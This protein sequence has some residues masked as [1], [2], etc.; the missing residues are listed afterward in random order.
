MADGKK[1]GL[2]V[3][4]GCGIVAASAVLSWF[5]IAPRA[6]EQKINASLEEISARLGRQITVSDLRLTGFRSA[7]LGQI[8]VSDAGHP[9]RI[10]IRLDGV[11]IA[12]THIPFG[13]DFSIASIEI[14]SLEVVLRRSGGT[15]NFDDILDK[16]KKRGGPEDAAAEGIS[17]WKRFVTPLPEIGIA[18]ASLTMDPVALRPDLQLGAVA[19]EALRFSPAEDHK[20][21]ET[22]DFGAPTVNGG[23]DVTGKVSFLLV[24]NKVP[25][26]YS[27]RFSGQIRSARDGFVSFLLPLSEKGAKPAFMT[28]NG[29]EYGFEAVRFA[30]PST[31]EIKMPQ[32]KIGGDP[33]FFSA[34]KF[35]AQFMQLPPKK[36]SGVYFKEIEI[37]QPQIQSAISDGVPA[38][39]QFMKIAEAG[40]RL[41]SGGGNVAGTDAAPET[42]K[43]E[44]SA[45]DYFFSQRLFVS[46]G[47]FAL[48][49][50]RQDGWLRL[51]I[52]SFNAEIGYR[53][54]RKV[55]D[56]KISMQ[57]REPAESKITL[58]G[59]YIMRGAERAQGT[60]SVESMRAGQALQRFGTPLR[61]DRGNILTA[62]AEA[63]TDPD[64]GDGAATGAQPPDRDP[65][66]TGAL[67]LK[68]RLP[69]M[70]LSC[71]ELA[72]KIDYAAQIP[73]ETA[74]LRA[75]L[76][77]A[78]AV[79]GI[80]AIS[81]EPFELKADV[82][83]DAH[84]SLKRKQIA[85]DAFRIGFGDSALQISAD[86]MKK[87]R[88]KKVKSGFQNEEAWHFDV[89]ADLLSMPMQTIFG[90]VPHALRTD[91]DGLQWQG[92]LGLSFKARGFFSDMAAAEHRFELALSDDFAVIAWPELRDINMLNNGFVHR[93]IDPNALAE[94]D[95]TVPPS[96]YP[97]DGGDIP[98]YVPRQNEDDIRALY[99]QW[100]LFD[101]INPWL[102]QL[103]T[104]TE[105]GSFF[106]HNGFSPLQVKAAMARN[107]DRKSF[108][109]GASTIS[110]QLVKNVFFDRTKSV[111]RK[112]QEVLYTWL[113]ESVVRI[114]KKRI[115]ELYFNIIEFGPE[116]Y[117]IEEAAKYY[118]GKRSRDLSLKEC[119]FLMAIIPNPRKG[120]IYRLLPSLPKPLAKTM[121]FYI[122][123]MYRRKCDPE[124]IE[125]MRARYAKLNQPVPFEPCCPPQADLQLMLG[126]DVLEFYIPNPKD[127]LQYGYRSD[128]YAEDGTPLTPMKS[129]HCGYLGG[130]IEGFGDDEG[131]APADWMQNDSI[132]GT[133]RGG[134]DAFDETG[135][136]NVKNAFFKSFGDDSF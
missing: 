44:K 25:E 71:A 105:D 55:L 123:E 43:K 119:A 69:A 64:L 35:R 31:I 116:I 72:F 102:V 70:D 37:V 28:Q 78:G 68:R 91:L 5:A 121:N 63:Q 40:K 113:M 131:D 128:L 130:N 6:A 127:T 107:I 98:L 59:Q 125:K 115:M 29:A 65:L 126:D 30:L 21:G 66:P 122:N 97:I 45:R 56:Y 8:A 108:S 89:R 52:A 135:S 109:R 1:I 112:F 134:D 95:I 87:M 4:I 101:D 23:G 9:D 39:Y 79:F 111:A 38:A 62:S 48:S 32:I 77:T 81:R 74:D 58:D 99:P 57:L 50:S 132:F 67:L 75:T 3:G 124:A 42:G 13:S 88:K 85:F 129:A 84:I 106:T 22:V 60:F 100:V 53:S 24:E 90:S 51:N 82:S 110:M 34:Q 104:T 12:L 16:L 80:P 36:V 7:R 93:V 136:K 2:G 92:S 14:D 120:A 61:D 86:F 18:S 10:G 103:I 11:G 33:P 49:D 19:A 76:S 54:I 46:D 15:T 47:Q 26:T 118:F 83:A 94:H 96:I 117:G 73:D 114:P 20:T 133:I 27:S 17:G 41:F